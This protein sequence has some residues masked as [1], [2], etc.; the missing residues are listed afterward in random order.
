ME[1][2]I[3]CKIINNAIPCTKV[4]EDDQVLAFK[5]INP[6]APVHVLIIPKMHITSVN[7]INEENQQIVAHIFLTVSKLAKEL[8]IDNE[9]YRVV[10][11][12]GE[13]GGQTVGHLHFHLLGGRS[14]TWP[15]G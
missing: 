3:F 9:G 14:L 5:D 15:P 1:N 13:N 7:A 6:E 8:G 2:C 11:N 10:T 4:Y 12:I